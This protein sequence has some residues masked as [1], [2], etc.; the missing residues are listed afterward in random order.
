M[1]VKRNTRA[2]KTTV[3][4]DDPTQDKPQTTSPG[5]APADTYDPNERVSSAKADKAA[6]A[7][8]GH[9]TV[10]AVEPVESYE[11]PALSGFRTE[12]ITVYDAD[13]KP[14]EVTYNYDTGETTLPSGG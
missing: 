1:T 13:N 8:A 7:A 6:A 2:P 11:P 12:T 4:A 5:D 14:V 10:N 9:L 3:I